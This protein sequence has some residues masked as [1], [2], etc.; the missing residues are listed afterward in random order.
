M[1]GNVIPKCVE[2]AGLPSPTKI[3]MDEEIFLKEFALGSL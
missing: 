1:W 2:G 3:I